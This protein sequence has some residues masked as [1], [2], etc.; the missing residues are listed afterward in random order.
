MDGTLSLAGSTYALNLADL[1]FALHA[2]GHGAR[3]LNPLMEWVPA[4]IGYKVIVV[5]L[6]CRWLGSREEPLARFGLG[7]CAA[8]YGAVDLW[9]IINLI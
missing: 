5:G 8:V 4:M 1:L 3:E 6:L 7:L 2:L 9:H